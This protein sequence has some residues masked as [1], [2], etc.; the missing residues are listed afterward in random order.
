MRKYDLYVNDIL[1]TISLIEDTTNGYSFEKFTEDK[2]LVDATAMRLQVI[3]ESSKKLP[4]S[5]KNKYK[6]FDWA[7]FK[8][9]RNIISHAYFIINPGILFRT[10]KKDIPILKKQI[11]KIKKDLE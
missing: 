2:N 6:E 9:L 7:I 3:G 5:T 8:N 11:L 1:R 10:V 4:I